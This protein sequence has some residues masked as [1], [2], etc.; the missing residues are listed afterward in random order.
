[1][2][3]PGERGGLVAAWGGQ[4]THPSVRLLSEEGEPDRIIVEKARTLVFDAVEAGWS[5]PPY[6]PIGLADLKGIEVEANPEVVDARTSL[7]ASGGL[8]IEFNPNQ[9][10]GRRRYSIAH[11]IAH[12]LF[13]DV[14]ETVRHRAAAAPDRDDDWQLELLCNMAAAEI[15]MPVGSLPAEADVGIGIDQILTLRSSFDVSVEAIAL[16]LVKLARQP[17]AAF[18]ASRRD[19]GA[20]YRLDYLW[21][22]PAW[23]PRPRP[24]GIPAATVVSQ[25]GAIGFTAKGD[26]SW[27]G[28]S[29]G[30]HVE[31]VGI[32]P[33]PGQ[34]IPRV[35]G[36]VWPDDS[37]T[38]A[39]NRVVHLR[40]SAIEPRGQG[41]RLLIHVV[42]DRTPRWGGGFAL[43][44]GR[45]WPSVQRDFIEWVSEE[46]R[47]LQLGSVRGSEAS[48]DLWVVSMIAQRGYGPSAKPRIRYHALETA[49][50]QVSELAKEL[51][52][53]VH[54]PRLGAGQAGGSWPIVE[55]LL[56]EM[57][58]AQGVP[59]TIYSLPNAPEPAQAG[60]EESRQLSL[61]RT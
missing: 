56:E 19:G 27:P 46:R 52:A 47:R 57:L 11:E 30:L 38:W 60:E 61:T 31:C 50:G 29:V 36:V 44:V 15:L 13:S 35:V 54:G 58:C 37:G 40:G 7:A 20:D 55:G 8:F 9:P 41:P 25:C 51:G 28:L 45:K 32:P 12:T 6:D 23:A 24:T 48:H 17:I 42:N 34:R 43:E 5:G 10:R 22:S 2:G 3:A 39:S 49:L 4:W 14:A 59:V 53:S 21:T 16:R 33:Y 26:E 1:M 18:A